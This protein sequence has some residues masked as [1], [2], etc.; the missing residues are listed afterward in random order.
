MKI[1]VPLI[2]K[3]GG[4]LLLMCCLLGKAFSQELVARNYSE[5]TQPYVTYQKPTQS[6]KQ[7]LDQLEVAYKVNFAYERKLLEGKTTGVFR[8]GSPEADIEEVLKKTLQPHQ[9]TFT[10]VDEVYIIRADR[11]NVR[12]VE[13][14]NIGPLKEDNS[15]DAN[16]SSLASV[17][18]QSW[19]LASSISRIQQV[20]TGTVTDAEEG[21]GLPGVNVLVQGTTIGTVTDVEGNYRIEAPD[22]ATTLVFSSVGYLTQEVEIGSQSVINLTLAPDIQS[23]SEVVV[24]G[25]GT[26]EKREVTGAISSISSEAITQQAVPSVDQAMAGRVAGVQVS[27]NSGAPGGSISLRVRGIGTPGN[28]EPL[29]VIDGIP[30]FGNTLSTLNP[31]DIESI[32]V[33]K[34]AASGAIYGSRAANGVVIIT[35]KRGHAG[36]TQ[37]DVDYYYGIQSKEKNL[38]VLDGPT[39]QEFIRDFNALNDNPDDDQNIFTNPANT[40]WENEIFRTAPM[41]NA[42]VSVS[43]GSETSTYL[44]SLG[45]FGQEGIIRGS[46]FD[47]F[48]LRV[49]TTNDVGER[50][51]IGNNATVSRTEGNQIFE[52]Q[53]FNAAIPLSVIYPPVIP[54]RLPDGTLG[55]PGNVGISFIRANPLVQTDLNTRENE[56]FRF[57]GNV[58]A[59]YDITEGL[60]YRLNLGGDFLYG[61]SNVFQVGL[62]PPGTQEQIS[63]GSRT[64]RREWIW[65]IENTLSYEREFGNGHNLDLLVGATQ[66][67]STFSFHSSGRQ[68]FPSNDLIAL[69]AGSEITDVRG[70]LRNW[71]LASFLGRVN[72]NFRD[73]YF[74]SATVRR[75]GSSRFQPGEN[76]WGTFPSVSAGWLISDEDFF[77]SSIISQVKIRGSWGQLGNQEIAPF[78]YLPLLVNNASYSFGGTVVPGIYAAQPANEDI[79]WETSTQ[80]GVGTDL[81]FFEDRL[82]LTVDYYNK[83]TDGILLEGTLPFAY[84]YLRNRVPQFPVVNAGVI[85]NRGFEFDLGFRESEG[86]FQWSANANLATVDNEVL[87]LGEGGPIVRIDEAIST[88]TDV[89]QAIGSF[90][91]YVVEGIFQNQAEIEALNPNPEENIYYQSSGTVP[92]DFKF[93]DLDDNGVVDEDDRTYIGNPIPDF[94]YG[95]SFNA[96]YQG[97]DLSFAFQGVQGNDIFTKIFQQAGDFT[98]PDNKFTTLYENVWRGEG[99]SNSV[100]RIATDNAN[101]NYRNSTYY[102]QDGSFLRLRS[103]QIGYSLPADLLENIN[104][105]KA[106]VYV[107]GQNLLT[108]DNYEFGLDPEI[109]S[110][111]E[112]NAGESSN[113]LNGVDYGRYPIPR[114]VTVGVNIGF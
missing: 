68:L 7:L 43:G 26:Q 82:T 18:S 93:K 30:V 17:V 88:R 76:Q 63:S 2:Q 96:N 70:Q 99:T 22:D 66:Q 41:Q 112:P 11:L 13:K 97:F 37:I 55:A 42:T 74:L 87:S 98:K 84:G 73:R 35:T 48:S 67:K 101:D 32:E 47:R 10:K 49:N 9:L 39:Y 24:I 105:R 104:L 100:P 103:L 114:V 57:L 16:S 8:G 109:G 27:Q 20:I 106:R 44:L 81:T 77:N 78:Q 108:F 64:D 36:K 25:Y 29:Y 58:F 1:T 46:G 107:G 4:M 5:V 50:F 53:V 91:G 6:L 75:D 79:T 3:S 92:G 90:Y 52:N 28:S 59:E 80:I 71:A 60:T 15:S 95:F 62:A 12:P 111:V 89:G 14:I 54:A 69:D 34:D 23:L 110:S 72:Y 40:N 45:Y 56:E 85:R 102:I 86:D 21:G 31:N 19:N 113:T 94:T 51:R 33:L 65:L 61:G 38:D 83:E